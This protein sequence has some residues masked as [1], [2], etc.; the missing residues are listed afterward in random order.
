MTWWKL[1]I[2]VVVSGVVSSTESE[3]EESERLHFFRWWSIENQ[4]VNVGSRS[5]RIN[6]SQSTFPS[7]V[8]GLVLLLLFPTPTIW[9]SQDHERNVS[10]GIYSSSLR[11]GTKAFT[12]GKWFIGYNFGIDDGAQNSLSLTFW[13]INIVLMSHV[14]SHVTILLQIVNY[15]PIGGRF[16]KRNWE[17]HFSNLY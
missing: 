6:Q 1:K 5:G 9:F 17:K 7:F 15:W 14:I 13:S 12:C 10:D 8:I 11:P 16:K 4:I 3:S 2:G